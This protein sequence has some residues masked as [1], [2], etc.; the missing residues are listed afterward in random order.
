MRKRTTY[1]LLVVALLLFALAVAVYL[2]QKAP[3]E[4]AR[5]LPDSDAIVFLDLQ[6]LRTLTHFERSPVA[7]SATYQQFID[8]TGIVAERDLDRVAFALHGMADPTG[9]NGAVAFSEVFEGHFDSN[10]L[11]RYLGSIAIAQEVYAGRTV[12]AIRSENRT[13]RVVILAYD[14]IAASNMPTAE[15]IHSIIERQQ[16]AASPFSGSSLLEARYRDVPAFS[17]AWAIGQIARPFAPAGDQHAHI[18]LLGLELPVPADATLIAS[19][20]LSPGISNGLHLDGGGRV[21][22]RV[23][24]IAPDSATAAASVASLTALANLLRSIEDAR[25]SAPETPQSDAVR[26]LADSVQ[27]VQHDTL[28]RLTASVP[29]AALRG[30]ATEAAPTPAASQQTPGTQPRP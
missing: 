12:Y 6:P 16:A 1:T 23:D 29:V 17:S 19:V 15:Q 10:R 24:E 11:A 21:A 14:T 27:I 25:H 26:A 22:F 3:P 18:Q 9:P 30:F 8:A 7:R 4:V 20:R 28:A 13:L 2:R 5:L